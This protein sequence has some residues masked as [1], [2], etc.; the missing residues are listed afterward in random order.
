MNPDPSDATLS[1]TVID[2][3]GDETSLL[4]QLAA[5]SRPSTRTRLRTERIHADIVLPN[6]PVI[7]GSL[8]IL[9]SFSSAE[10]WDL[11][12]RH[13]PITGTIEK[14]QRGAIAVD[15]EGKMAVVTGGGTGMGRE[16]VRQ[17]I[18]G[19]CHVATCDVNV[20]AM[21]E[22]S[23][24]ALAETQFEVR[25]TT[26]LCDVSDEADVLAFLATNYKLDIKLNTLTS[27]STTLE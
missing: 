19:G 11:G 27:Y 2:D 10:I 6:S 18:G 20:D 12:W 3:I 22:T 17:L 14:S 24:I 13:C 16:L 7:Q 25:L 23:E 5:T 1:T 26:H 4:E 15:F 21:E 9:I 8:K